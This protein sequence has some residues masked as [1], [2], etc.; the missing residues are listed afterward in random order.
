ME[1]LGIIWCD[2]D[3]YGMNHTC[4]VS[5]LLSSFQLLRFLRDAKW[6]VPS[7]TLVIWHGRGACSSKR[8]F[9]STNYQIK[10][11]ISMANWHKLQVDI[12]GNPKVAVSRGKVRPQG[13]AQVQLARTITATQSGRG[14]WNTLLFNVNHYL[15]TKQLPVRLH[16]F[17][18]HKYFDY[19]ISIQCGKPMST[20]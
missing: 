7:G 20:Q 1:F 4:L 15:E 12:V 17:K 10:I 19:K 13:L 18:W 9:S 14:A 6:Q 3:S 8:S 2:M 11:V 5:S 16:M